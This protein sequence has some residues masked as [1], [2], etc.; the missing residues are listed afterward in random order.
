MNNENQLEN[1]VSTVDD[2][3]LV[4]PSRTQTESVSQ[5]EGTRVKEKVLALLAACAVTGAVTLFCIV[6]FTN[7]KV[8]PEIANEVIVKIQENVMRPPELPNPYDTVTVGAK[9]AIVYD[10]HAKKV[11]YSKNAQQQLPLASLTKMMTALLAVEVLDETKNIAVSSS[12]LD[13]EGDSGLFSNESWNIKDLISFT[14]VTSS[15]DGAGAL[16]AAVGSL[17]H[18]TPQT[19]PEVNIENMDTFVQTMNNRASE[20]GLQKTRYSN[21]TGLDEEATGGVG[22]AEDMSKLLAYIWENEPKVLEY[23]N[24]A[25]KAFVSEDNLVH[26]AENT[27]ESVQHIPGLIGGKTGFTNLAGGNLAV[28]YDAGLNHPIV[29]VVLG[30]TIE[31]RFSDVETLVEATYAYVENGWYAFDETSG[32]TPASI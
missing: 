27:N 24:V 26:V 14:M 31:G 10:V 9:S 15:N 20:L 18:S 25:S 4:L 7:R 13:I 8:E 2:H 11:L 23:T 28:I 22:S 16:A 32:S 30:S 17:L 6:E 19:I 29:V 5:Y 12:A 3:T 21:P 1:E